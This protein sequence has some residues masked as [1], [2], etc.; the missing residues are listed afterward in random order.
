MNRPSLETIVLNNTV[1]MIILEGLLGSGA[2][3]GHSVV[4]PEGVRP[5]SSRVFPEGSTSSRV[6]PEGVTA[7]RPSVSRPLPPRYRLPIGFVRP[8]GALWC[9]TCVRK[10]LRENKMSLAD[11]PAEECWHARKDCPLMIQAVE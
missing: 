11:P 5:T 6:F 1:E 7:S 8:D 2:P 4:R 10:S 9:I 3:S